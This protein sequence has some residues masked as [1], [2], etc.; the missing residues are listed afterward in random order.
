MQ[1]IHYLQ[2]EVSITKSKSPQNN[3]EGFINKI[4]SGN[5]VHK[6]PQSPIQHF[7]IR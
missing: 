3:T 7:D 1:K 5:L 4:K 6:H 2:L